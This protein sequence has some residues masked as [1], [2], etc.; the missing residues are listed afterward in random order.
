MYSNVLIQAITNKFSVVFLLIVHQQT[1]QM[2]HY[3]LAPKKLVF[4]PACQEL[5]LMVH[6]ECKDHKLLV[7]HLVAK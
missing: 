2:L 3:H 6:I 1:I 7:Q 4:L 5:H